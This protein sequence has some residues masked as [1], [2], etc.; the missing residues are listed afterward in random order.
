MKNTF[1]VIKIWRQQM[2]YVLKITSKQETDRH[3]SF[4]VNYLSGWTLGPPNNEHAYS[5]TKKRG[6][7]LKRTRKQTL[8]TYLSMLNGAE[9]QI[10]KFV[11]IDIQRFSIINFP[12][13]KL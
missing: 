13:D 6:C 8:F 4:K 12:D 11:K 5:Q 9:M 10:Y 2:M 1:N 7:Y 3:V